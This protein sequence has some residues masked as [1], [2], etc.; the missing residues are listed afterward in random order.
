M[1]QKDNF[2][3]SESLSPTVDID[4]FLKLD[5]RVGQILYAEP[6]EQSQAHLRLTVDLGESL[7]TRQ[8]L[9]RIAKHFSPSSV[10]GRKVV[11]LANLKPHIVLGHSSEGVLLAASDT[12]G[13]L[14][15]LS[16][17]SVIAPGSRVK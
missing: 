4:A 8:I 14:E 11:V 9:S 10:V 15:L 13:N 16:P 6:V 3:Q 17:G 5:L 7:G 12:K 2:L 1:G